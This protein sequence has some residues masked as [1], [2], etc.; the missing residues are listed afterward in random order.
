ME[1]DLELLRAQLDALDDA[2]L[3]LLERRARLS[4][5]VGELKRRSGGRVRQPEREA[6]ILSRLSGLAAQK[7]GPLGQAQLEN[8]YRA[9]FA[10]S[11]Q[12][13]EGE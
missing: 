6:A 5:R 12:L 4:L 9:I 1:D 8:I 10:V 2:L 13:Q 7:G 3:E 11:R